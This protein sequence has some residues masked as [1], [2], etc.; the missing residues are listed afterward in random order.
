MLRLKIINLVILL[1]I[2]I[3][4]VQV[5]YA[6]MPMKQFKSTLA[7]MRSVCGPKFKITEADMDNLKNGQFPEDQ[8]LKCYV[9]CVAE[10]AGTLGKKGDISA[11]KTLKQ[12]DT[13]VPNEM[14]EDAK[15]AFDA[16]I[17]IRKL[18]LYIIVNYFSNNL[19]FFF[20]EKNYKD[21]CDKVFYTAKCTYEFNP[22]V[23][24]FP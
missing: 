3:C 4:L 24:L 13:L 11:P 18:G 12:I 5:S 9:K 16:C 21:P 6:G 22:N 10:M 20:S 14:Q 15:T 1:W 7:M 23:F 2:P 8:E 19:L 17:N